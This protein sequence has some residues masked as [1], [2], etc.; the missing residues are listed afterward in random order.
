MST[1][2]KLVLKLDANGSLVGVVN[3]AT[4]EVFKLGEAAK[5][6]GESTQKLGNES[7]KAFGKTRA[8]V[9]SIS[10]QLDTMRGSMSR[11]FDIA[12]IGGTAIALAKVTDAYKAM[13]GQITLATL[14]VAEF[15][16]VQRQVAEIANGVYQAQ[17][18][19]VK[20]YS[21]MQP[22]MSALGHST[23]ESLLI[24]QTFNKAL[25][26]TSP[27]TAE[28]QST[29]LQFAQAMGSGVL[30]GE[31]FNS[32]ME[33]GRGVAKALADGLGVPIDALRKMAEEGQLTANVVVNA[34]QSQASVVESKFAKLPLTVGGSF[35]VFANNTQTFIGELDKATGASNA[36]AGGVLT[37]ANNL[38]NLAIIGGISA[39]AYGAAVA[40]KAMNVAV[41]EAAAASVVV[42][43]RAAGVS[44]ALGMQTAATVAA[45]TATNAMIFSIRALAASTMAFM[46]TPIGAAMTVAAG[47]IAYF[48][49][50]SDDA[51][52]STD[53]LQIS[54]A[55]MIG[56]LDKLG[57][58]ET[59]K[60][61]KEV[62]QSIRDLT[63]AA[64]EKSL[65]DMLF[66]DDAKLRENTNAII[67]KKQTM[68]ELLKA[69][70]HKQEDATTAQLALNTAMNG[71][72]KSAEA[73]A[74]LSKE[75]ALL[76]LSIKDA[77]IAKAAMDVADKGGSKDQVNEAARIAGEMADIKAVAEAKKT[78]ASQAE[79]LL[80]E[81]QDKAKKTANE[82]QQA[83][84]RS[85]DEEYADFEKSLQGQEN[86]SRS[87]QSTIE[88]LDPL[89]RAEREYSDTQRTLNA[90]L[91]DAAISQQRYNQLM[92]EASKKLAEAK[93]G[94]KNVTTEMKM[95]E[96]VI[97]RVDDGFVTVW[98]D[99]LS[100]SKDA[101][102]S[103]KQI[104]I[105][106][107]AEIAHAY[108]TQKIVLAIGGSFGIGGLSGAASAAT[109]S[110]MMNA[111]GG[112]SA[113]SGTGAAGGVAT[114]AAD[115]ATSSAVANVGTSTVGGWMSS[116]SAT[117]GGLSSGASAGL[118]YLG[119]GDLA[120]AGADAASLWGN[121]AYGQAAGTA[122][123]AYLPVIGGALYGYQSTGEIGG[124]AAG[125]AGA[126]YGAQLGTM[127]MPG[128]GTAIG[129]VLGSI[130]GG[131]LYTGIFGG[132]KEF[133]GSGVQMDYNGMGANANVNTY[134][135]FS[136]DGGWFRSSSQWTEYTRNDQATQLVNESL[137]K[138]QT[139][140]DKVAN[141]LGVNYTGIGAQS[142]SAGGANGETV[143]GWVKTIFDKMGTA[144]LSNS[145]QYRKDNE[146]LLDTVSRM[147]NQF[148]GMSIVLDKVNTSLGALSTGSVSA[149]EELSNVAGG[150][151]K[152]AQAQ[153]S[154]FD[155]FYSAAEKFDVLQKTLSQTLNNVGINAMPTTVA[156]Y[157]SMVASQDITTDAGRTA[158]YAL[159]SNAS[160]FKSYF[161]QTGAQTPLLSQTSMARFSDGGFTG[162]GA[163]L[164]PAGI[165]H[166]GEY[167][168]PAW[169][170]KKQPDLVTQLESI[171]SN[172]FASGGMVGGLVS[173]SSDNKLYDLLKRMVD[174][175]RKWDGDGM[176]MVRA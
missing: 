83:R 6:A 111:S 30:R 161:D 101:F 151:D 115:Y 88:S 150:F 77:A 145:E 13:Q 95:M 169:M 157:K 4:G 76:G 107:L 5:K 176:P 20:L 106:T 171:R 27:T 47:S 84:K 1:D 165:V 166:K 80:K 21:A 155:L 18:A 11:A 124:A 147:V 79:R 12:A 65:W 23:N 105:N 123:G 94:T 174:I 45:T 55:R 89:A 7:E 122:A 102:S 140:A 78:A 96:N 92:G 87:I 162:N 3:Q 64:Q 37:L 103:L 66:G 112:M 9:E 54:V 117:A 91:E 62:E 144:I 60:K 160:S 39:S 120:F 138:G 173:T 130:G 168:V 33:N 164:E 133:T 127:V 22:S 172:G 148:E 40:F 24:V 59:A 156:A 86:R 128:I 141:K 97:R 57:K 129:A 19:V 158:Y 146:S 49:L 14:S 99:M 136:K 98:K 163:R 75:Y 44:G 121:G 116:L 134:Q 175:I 61:V 38:G 15:N 137:A 63:T 28:A 46:A 36:F 118:G 119:T 69:L 41:L 53:D 58:L 31:E 126:Y 104:A 153:S 139:A 142:F 70:K 170:V 8:G 68:I 29:I 100:G 108:T 125:A 56:D 35:Q 135:S 131:A 32:I 132:G 16:N 34:L 154:Y 25:A 113:I 81:Q 43:T 26:L 50:S 71:T 110:L 42:T 52:D 109:G 82:I 48:A 67:E 149:L 2:L 85:Q 143:E 10:R 17:G 90:G 74:A 114:T 152:L 167:V 93:T 159:I 73:I 51:K 72:A